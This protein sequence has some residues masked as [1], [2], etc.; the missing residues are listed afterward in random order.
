MVTLTLTLDKRRASK[1]GK[2]PLFFRIGANRKYA[3]I[4][5]GFHLHA[6][7]F[8]EVSKSI[9][10]PDIHV[11]V[12]LLE[13]K[14]LKQIYS[15]KHESNLS[16]TALE[17]KD[18]LLAKHANET[19]IKSFWNEHIKSLEVSRRFGG[20]RTYRVSLNTLEKHSNL[21]VE[22]CKFSYR[23]LLLIESSL[24]K[25]GVSTNGIGV[26]MRSFRAICN[27]A[28]H[29]DIVS[30][31]WYPFRKYKIK[32]EKTSPR[33]LAQNELKR[34]FMLNLPSDHI[35][36][37]SWLI[38]K[39]IFMLRGINITDLLLLSSDNIKGERIIYRRAKTGKLYSILITKEISHLFSQFKPTHTILGILNDEDLKKGSKL[40]D[41]IAQKRKVINSHLRHL[42]NISGTT[43]CISTYVF[44][45]TYANIAKQLGYS[46]DLIAEALG[47]EYGNSVTGIYLEQFDTELIDQ[48]NSHITSSISNFVN[49]N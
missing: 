6:S 40:I 23:D 43:E 13:S 46:K 32:K 24:Y 31:E 15:L 17:I 26:Y 8:N 10:D 25:S 33:T 9:S 2:F 49:I 1:E 12:K 47:H 48:M 21:N 11:T 38:G 28:I 42:G 36:Y 20:A 45:Y 4:S 19:T 35:Y 7:N 3:H 5:T 44:R 37:R 34:Y 29:M 18:I 22:F 14:Y 30:Y 16:L 39:L 27:K 41:I